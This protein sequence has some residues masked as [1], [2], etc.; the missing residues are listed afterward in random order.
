MN[1]LTTIATM[2]CLAT[3]AAAQTGTMQEQG[4]IVGMPE[5]DLLQLLKD[6]GA[7]CTSGYIDGGINC[8]LDGEE[9]AFAF[10]RDRRVSAITHVS[11]QRAGPTPSPTVIYLTP[12]RPAPPVVVTVPTPV[13][14]YAPA[15]SALPDVLDLHANNMRAHI[16]GTRINR[17]YARTRP[18]E[19]SWLTGRPRGESWLNPG[20]P[21]Y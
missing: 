14:S 17:H 10:T 4:F 12:P 21:R 5:A 1:R 20:R 7:Q 19:R 2:L 15:P 6:K 8:R 11:A 18:V 3:G 13:P 16:I 9:V